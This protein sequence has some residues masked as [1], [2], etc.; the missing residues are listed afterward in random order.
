MND[1]TPGATAVDVLPRDPAGAAALRESL[2]ADAEYMANWKDDQGKQSTL[3]FLRW[4][5]GGNDP[6]AWAGRRRLLLML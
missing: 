1:P 4:V 3:A 6:D 2:T 5:S